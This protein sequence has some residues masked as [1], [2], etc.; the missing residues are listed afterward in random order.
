MGS[1]NELVVGIG[2]PDETPTSVID[3]LDFLVNGGGIREVLSREDRDKVLVAYEMLELPQHP[4][5]ADDYPWYELLGIDTAN[6]AGLP[7]G[8]L[9][10]D[11]ILKRYDLTIRAKTKYDW[12][13]RSFLHWVAQYSDTTGVVGYTR[14]IDEPNYFDLIWFERGKAYFQELILD[15]VQPSRRTEITPD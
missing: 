12:E 10:K 15:E 4:F 1:W 5:F 6:F 2:F 9:T 3:I 11:K 13:I 14:N 8:E 7:Y